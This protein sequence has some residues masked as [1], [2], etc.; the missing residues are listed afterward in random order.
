MGIH[1]CNNRR[2]K[3]YS[4]K[5]IYDLLSKSF[6]TSITNVAIFLVVLLLMAILK[7]G[8]QW[9]VVLPL[10]IFNG[11]IISNIIKNDIQTIFSI[12]LAVVFTIIE[13]ILLFIIF[14][15]LIKLIIKPIDELFI[16]IYKDVSSQHFMGII[17]GSI[18]F[19]VLTLIVFIFSLTMKYTTGTR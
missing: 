4:N 2:I 3:M 12:F 11:I 10:S 1:Y 18:V 19:C 7:D 17:I 14:F 13:S 8:N 15:V 5:I 9:F 16:K 6:I